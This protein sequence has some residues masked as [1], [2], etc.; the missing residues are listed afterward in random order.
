MTQKFL[1]ATLLSALILQLHAGD[2]PPLNEEEQQ[3][4]Q[5]RQQAAAL[6]RL[7]RRDAVGGRQEELFLSREQRE[8]EMLNAQVNA[9]SLNN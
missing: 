7:I 2:I 4:Q 5:A 3:H 8:A 9:L 1:S 6:P